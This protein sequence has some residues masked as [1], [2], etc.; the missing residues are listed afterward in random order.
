MIATMSSNTE[1]AS[2]GRNLLIYAALVA[3]AA[4]FTVLV[5]TERDEREVYQFP[6]GLDGAE[7]Y[8]LEANPLD[9]EKP[10]IKLAG[11]SYYAA[12]KSIGRWDRDVVPVARDDDGRYIIYQKT[13]K[14]GGGGVEEGSGLYLKVDR[15]RYILVKPEMKIPPAAPE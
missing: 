9:P 5:W 4:A 8:D 14:V 12:A 7:V 2:A 11:V 10:M 1:K 13:T 6:T 15:D 3:V